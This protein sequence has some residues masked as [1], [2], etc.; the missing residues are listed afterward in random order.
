MK[1][2]LLLILS[3]LIIGLLGCRATQKE[4]KNPVSE[5]K[6]TNPLDDDGADYSDPWMIQAGER[7]YYCGSTPDNTLIIKRGADS[8]TLLTKSDHVVW[9]APAGT[10]YSKELWAPE[11]H[12]L[13]GH[14][15]I[16][17]AADDGNNANHRMYALRGGSDPADPLAG[18]YTFQ[19]KVAAPTDRWAIDGTVL[20]LNHQLYFIWSG[21]AGSHN[22]AQNLYIAPMS[23]PLTI[24]GE[25]VM[26]STPDHLFEQH[27]QPFVNEGPEVL[28]HKGKIMVIYS[29]SGS[30]TDDYCLGQLTLNGDAPLVA[31][32]WQKKAQPVFQKTHEVFGP[33]HCSFIQSPSHTPYLVYH[34]A[35]TQGSGWQRNIRMQAFG[36][37]RDHTPDF[38]QPI[39][40]GKELT[41][42]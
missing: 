28:Q 2:R 23:D 34:A 18:K 22:V 20:S 39:T 1:G 25:R 10:D 5:I 41:F 35:V 4:V 6:Y 33:G 19:G 11:L 26:I 7:Y 21:W 3:V 32:N 38:E 42:K 13:E 16:Y 12:F 15:Y 27:G 36:W 8:T 14:W 30:W 17:F 40:P 31:A 9:S 24:S 37:H 29:A